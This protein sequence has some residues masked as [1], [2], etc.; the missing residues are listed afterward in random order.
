MVSQQSGNFSEHNFIFPIE[1]G[2]QLVITKDL[3][4]VIR[5]LQKNIS[6]TPLCKQPAPRRDKNTR[7]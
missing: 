7:E 3:L 1:N 6:V 5:I 2:L 4:L